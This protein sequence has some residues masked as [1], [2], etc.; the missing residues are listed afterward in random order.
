MHLPKPWLLLALTAPL[1]FLPGMKVSGAEI[2]INGIPLDKREELVAKVRPRLDFIKQREASSWRADDAAFFFKRLLI[3]AGHADAEVDWKLPG[4]N[5]IEINARPGVRYKY[6]EI[7]ANRMG[8]LTGEQLRQYFLQPLIETELV[9]A[10]KA[11]FIEEYSLKGASNVQ[12]FLK[13]QGYWQAS[14][15]VANEKYDRV[16]KQ[17]NIQLNLSA[18]A[19][20]KLARPSFNGMPAEDLAEILPDVQPFIGE[21]ADSGNMTKINSIV[22]NYYREK[23]YHFA[24]IFVDAKHV[25]GV[26]TLIFEINRGIRYTVDDI[27][28]RGNKYTKTKRIRRYFDGLKDIHFDRNAADKALSNLLA[29]GAFRSATLSPVPVPGGMLDLQID[30]TEA[31]AKALKSYIGLGSFEGGIL[32]MSYTDLNLRGNLLKLNARGEYS[33]RGFLGEL[34]I[35]EPHFAGEPIQLTLR[36]FLLQRLYD[37]YDKSEAGVEASLLAKYHDHYSSRLF[38]GTSSVGTSTSSLTE[39]ELGPDGYLNTRLGFEQTVDFRDDPLLPSSGFYARGILEFGSITG[40]ESTTYLKTVFDGSYRFVLG[41]KNFFVTRFSTGAIKPA[42]VEKLPID[43]RLFSGGSDSV[44]SFE[45]RQLGPRSLS[46]D[47]LGGQAYWNASLEYIRPIKDPI[48]GVLFFDM[49]QVYSD[50][51]D[52]GSF[53]DPSYAIGAGIRVDLPIGAVRLEYGHNLNQREGEPN[54]TFHFTIGTSF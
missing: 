15:S 4:G 42:D 51:G 18:R 14:V 29:S 41:E 6:G 40:G 24:Q 48:K 43:L 10:D 32:G 23:G 46:D 21:T 49:G 3:R 31:E 34:S 13:S 27:V 12:N 44:R 28:V 35:T 22:E 1:S 17:V 8:P 2:R 30:V 37:G 45:Q 16:S 19:K 36:G 20:F 38:L 26:T 39:Q 9:A 53:S 54:G 47:P 50:V 52:W 7:K 25:G 33:G 5:V 11:P